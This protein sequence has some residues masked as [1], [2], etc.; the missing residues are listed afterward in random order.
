MEAHE[1]SQVSSCNLVDSRLQLTVLSSC[2]LACWPDAAATAKNHFQNLRGSRGLVHRIL[3]NSLVRLCKARKARRP[4]AMRL[5][6]A[7]PT[8]PDA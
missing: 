7:S 6:D 8:Q 2:S 3:P 1:L 4:P 5:T